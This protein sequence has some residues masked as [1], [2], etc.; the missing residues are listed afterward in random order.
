MGS[1]LRL[2][3]WPLPNVSASTGRLHF[4]LKFVPQAARGLQD[5]NRPRP[6]LGPAPRARGGDEPM[7]RDVVIERLAEDGLAPTG[8]GQHREPRRAGGP[9]AGPDHVRPDAAGREW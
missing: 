7:I 2:W 5:P 6:P 9:A 4:R 3:R 8:G 1:L